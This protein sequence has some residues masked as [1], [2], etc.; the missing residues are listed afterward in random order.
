MEDN[1][2]AVVMAFE[3][4]RIHL[5]TS[6]VLIREMP[7]EFV[8]RHEAWPGPVMTGRRGW[9]RRLEVRNEMVSV[10]EGEARIGKPLGSESFG[11]DNEYSTDR[12]LTRVEAFE[13]SRYLITNGEFWE[14]VEDGGSCLADHLSEIHMS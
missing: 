2:W 10:S 1:A 8:E 14:F 9:E 6:S 12:K 3:H 11:W 4:E 13:A 5:E 7:L